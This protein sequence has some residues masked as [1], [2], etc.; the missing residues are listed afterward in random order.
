MYTKYLGKS[1]VSNNYKKK[2][3]NCFTKNSIWNTL[4]MYIA[5]QY[6]NWNWKQQSFALNYYNG[7]VLKSKYRKRISEPEIL[8]FPNTIQF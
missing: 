2:T 4:Q 8:S 7:D 1:V 5:I 3:I 6:L